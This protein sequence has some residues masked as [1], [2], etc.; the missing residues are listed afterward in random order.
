M[1]CQ[2]DKKET[3][4]IDLRSIPIGWD[5]EKVLHTWKEQG[6]IVVDSFRGGHMPKIIGPK[7]NFSVKTVEHKNFKDNG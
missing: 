7:I 1:K 3:L 4:V 2:E 6:V 5:V